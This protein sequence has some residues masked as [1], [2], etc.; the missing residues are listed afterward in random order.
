LILTLV[1]EGTVDQYT[2]EFDREISPQL[3]ML[4]LQLADDNQMQ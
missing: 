2:L 3:D 4:P 1:G